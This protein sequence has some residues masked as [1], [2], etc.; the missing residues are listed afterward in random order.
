MGVLEPEGF[1]GV[2]VDDLIAIGEDKVV[3]QVMEQLAKSVQ[4]GRT[5]QG[6]S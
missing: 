4:D 2:Y 1:L 3:D 5:H 6:C